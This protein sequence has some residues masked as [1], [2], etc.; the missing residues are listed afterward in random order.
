MPHLLTLVEQFWH[1]VPGGTAKAT[2]RTLAALLDHHE[3]TI[4][5]LAAAH[6]PVRASSGA[7]GGHAWASVP[8]GVS[9]VH[10]RLPRPVLYESWLRLGR[11]SIDRLAGPGS[12][13]WASSLIVPPTTIPVVSTVHD[14]DFLDRQELLTRRGQDFFPRVWRQAR[15]RSHRFVCPSAVVAEQCVR[16]GVEPGCVR[17]VPWGVDQPACPPELVDRVLLDLVKRSG[18]HQAGLPERFVL[19][20]APDQPRKNPAICALALEANDCAAVIVGSEP[21]AD[22]VDWFDRRDQPVI[23]LGSV[24][25]VELSALYHRA[26]ALLFP[27]LAEGFGLPVAEA[28]MHG[29][30][31]VTSRGTATEEVARGAAIV[32]D[33]DNDDEVA[34]ALG[35]VLDDGGLR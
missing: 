34:A 33:P 21:P 29:L 11:P 13:F 23:R 14:L 19:L 31:V 24:S 5:G 22:G 32:V 6:R 2:E 12:V 27:S 30:P 17:V 26:D 7:G 10:H 1:K 16:H 9:V 4:T 3:F 18:H 8:E 28:M 35:R 15:M 25:N 20:V